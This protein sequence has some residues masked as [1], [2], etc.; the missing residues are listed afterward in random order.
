MLRAVVNEL[1]QSHRTVFLLPANLYFLALWW[2]QRCQ[3]SLE[4][5]RRFCNNKSETVASVTQFQDSHSIRVR[6]CQSSV[7]VLMQLRFMK[8]KKKTISFYRV[9]GNLVSTACRCD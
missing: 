5:H 7:R 9:K 6:V 2:P 4:A 3:T 1:K 8:K